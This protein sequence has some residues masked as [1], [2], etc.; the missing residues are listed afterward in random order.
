M[1]TPAEAIAL[2]QADEIVRRADRVTALLE[3]TAR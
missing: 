1:S 3:K 2:V